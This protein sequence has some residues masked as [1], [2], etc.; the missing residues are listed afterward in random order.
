MYHKP[1][2]QQKEETKNFGWVTIEKGKGLQ[3]DKSHLKVTETK[4]ETGKDQNLKPTP[5]AIPDSKDKT[6]K[7]LIDDF[8]KNLP[9]TTSQQQKQE[10]GEQLMNLI[11]QM[12]SD[13][14]FLMKGQID[15]RKLANINE[16]DQLALGHFNYRAIVDHIRYYGIFVDWI[17]VSS[18]AINGLRARQFIQLA[19]A[20]SGSPQTEY[21]QEPSWIGRHITNRDYEEKAR[22]KGQTVIGK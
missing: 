21:V 14:G 22:A 7:E 17:L 18:N 5:L 12:G 15:E 8:I 9:Q 4:D 11:M 10:L 19:S 6:P 3:H 13:Q 1:T 2:V 16:S 20:Y